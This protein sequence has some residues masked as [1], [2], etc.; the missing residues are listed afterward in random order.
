MGCHRCPPFPSVPV[1]T[2][3]RLPRCYSSNG[4]SNV[5]DLPLGHLVPLRSS[6]LLNWDGSVAPRTSDLD[7][8][9]TLHLAPSA[10]SLFPRHGETLAAHGLAPCAHRATV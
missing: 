5:S 9:C 6:L 1:A 10:S 4:S 7:L 8:S 2:S 3:L